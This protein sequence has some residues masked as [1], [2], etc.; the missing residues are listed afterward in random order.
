MYISWHKHFEPRERKIFL[1]TTLYFFVLISVV[2][3]LKKKEK[4][5]KK[6]EIFVILGNYS[7]ILYSYLR[8][9]KDL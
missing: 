9:G 1:T 8:L 5:E 2:N 3:E 4:K 6:N 7:L